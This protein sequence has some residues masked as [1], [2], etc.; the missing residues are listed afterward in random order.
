MS[1]CILESAM[2]AEAIM[3]EE[4]IKENVISNLQEFMANYNSMKDILSDLQGYLITQSKI[5][6]EKSRL[7]GDGSFLKALNASR[8]VD[9]QLSKMNK[10]AK[11]FIGLMRDAL[12]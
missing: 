12:K 1:D 9:V 6:R 3:K 8:K 11:E 5:D 2:A 4:A 7:M 10:E